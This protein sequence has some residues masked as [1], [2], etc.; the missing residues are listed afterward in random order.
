MQR[1]QYM[2][3]GNLPINMHGLYFGVVVMTVDPHCIVH[4]ILYAYRGHRHVLCIENHWNDGASE[5]AKY[6]HVVKSMEIMG[7][8]IR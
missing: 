2:L 6:K 5:S 4:V 3:I 8:R 7:I 1:I